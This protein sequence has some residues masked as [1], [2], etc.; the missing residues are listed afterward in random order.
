MAG[1]R[2]PGWGCP[3][4]AW[5]SLHAHKAGS[6]KQL[7]SQRLTAKVAFAFLTLGLGERDVEGLEAE[8]PGL[9]HFRGLGGWDGRV[10]AEWAAEAW[11]RVVMCCGEEGRGAGKPGVRGWRENAPSG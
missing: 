3:G 8:G 9:G 1:G 6:G 7:C 2:R 5:Q 10:V 11:W 4:R